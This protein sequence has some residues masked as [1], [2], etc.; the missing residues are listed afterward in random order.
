M[1]TYECLIGHP[2]FEVP[3]SVEETHRA[4]ASGHVPFPSDGPR[5]SADAKD[6]ILKL[7]SREA[8]ARPTLEQVLAHPFIAPNL[9]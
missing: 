6:L 8:G 5:V 4:I 7:L 9:Q 1:L 2:P 3:H